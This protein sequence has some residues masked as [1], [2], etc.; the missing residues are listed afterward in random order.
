MFIIDTLNE[1][2]KYSRHLLN[3]LTAD[4]IKD[5]IIN[6]S[7]WFYKKHAAYTLINKQFLVVIGGEKTKDVWSESA[8]EVDLSTI[9]DRKD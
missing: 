6:E 5:E 1:S 7:N 3:E 8:Y 2:I 4:D 9:G